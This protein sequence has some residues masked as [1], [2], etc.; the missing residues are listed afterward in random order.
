MD[1]IRIIPDAHIPTRDNILDGPPESLLDA[2]RVFFLG[3]AAG[4]RL[5][6]EPRNRSMM[7]HPSVRTLQH[8]DYFGWVNRTMSRWLN[9][10]EDQDNDPDRQELIEELRET[11]N[12]LTRTVP[13]L[14]PF[15]ELIG[16]LPRAI[17]ETVPVQVNARRGRTPQVDWEQDYSHIL[18]GGQSLDRGYT[19]EGLTVTYMPRGRGVG[20]ADT[21]QQRARWFGYKANYLGYC[22]VYLSAGTAQAYRSY[23]EHEEDIRTRLRENSLRGRSLRDWKRAFLL[24]NDLRPTRNCVLGLDYMQD[25]YSNKW[26]ETRAPHDST[27][28]SAEN[29]AVVQ[30][31]VSE[32]RFA[33]SEGDPRRQ[34]HQ[35]HLVAS[36]ISLQ[37]AYQNLLTRLRMTRSTDSTR[38]TGLLLQIRRYLEERPDSTCTVYQMSGGRQRDR[39]VSGDEIPNLFQGAYPDNRG[40]IYRGDR[41]ARVEGELTIQIHNVRVL[42]ER[43]V[44]AEN[45][46]AITVWVPAAMAIDW[47][48][49]DQGSME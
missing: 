13:D 37:E 28:A 32:Y 31:F 19:V 4:L 26:F 39:S 21:I 5:R 24:D 14:L 1:L 18:V 11:Y 16:T 22:R 33:P 48:V 8:E 49:Q 46:P 2:M 45:V 15:E 36:G 3:V 27:E 6:G 41:Y 30:Q 20:N 7:V 43:R 9:T 42:E 10:L 29:R 17:R 12:D 35:I 23:T 25:A 40:E 44:I 47:L 38:F 34:P